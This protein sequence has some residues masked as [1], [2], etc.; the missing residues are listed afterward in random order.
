MEIYL[1]RHGKTDWN[2]MH[3]IQGKVDISLNEE[4]IKQAKEVRDKLKNIKF[5]KI[6]VSP[7]KRALETC[8]VITDDNFVVDKRL[9]E[10]SFGNL[11]GTQITEDCIKKHWDYKLNSNEGGMETIKELLDRLKKF[12]NDLL[13]NEEDDKILIVSHACSIKSIYFNLIGY[14]ENTDFLS[15][16]LDN[17]KVAK[18]TLKNN[19][20][21]EF[22]II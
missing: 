12:N 6:Y 19:K 14:D 7:L 15:F 10:R 17:C 18:I 11:E 5:N 4:G 9:C 13:D 20:I 1:V 8:K 3:K 16:Y 21:E 22:K 2:V